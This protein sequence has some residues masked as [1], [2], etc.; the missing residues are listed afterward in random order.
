MAEI[1]SP[2]TVLAFSRQFQVDQIPAGGLKDRIEANAEE[3]GAIAELLGLESLGSLSLAFELKPV[4]AKCFV[5]LGRL[6]ARLKQIC[7]VSL[8]PI[9]VDIDRA[10]EM[11]FAPEKEFLRRQEIVE[12]EL[13]DPA[14]MDLEPILGGAIDLGHLAYECIAT[15]I[16]PYPRKQGI[17]FEWKPAGMPGAEE[18]DGPFS[19][20]KV[21]KEK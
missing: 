6:A 15:E 7:V 2:E 9:E 3:R 20:L 8:E 16:E 17:D 19:A 4:G 18:D 10:I 13:S 11:E 21:L 14:A 5:V 1:G 12:D